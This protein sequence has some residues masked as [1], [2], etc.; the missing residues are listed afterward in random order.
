MVS[1]KET[2]VRARLER[3]PEMTLSL[4][5]GN[6]GLRSRAVTDKEKISSFR[7]RPARS[8]AGA[9]QKIERD[10]I[11]FPPFTKIVKGHSTQLIEK[12]N[13]DP[14]RTQQMGPDVMIG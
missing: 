2:S 14:G 11:Y 9:R 8:V 5:K 7:R 6:R 10:G 3:L 1:T 12:T 13:A 4:P